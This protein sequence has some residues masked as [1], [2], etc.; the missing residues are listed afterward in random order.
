MTPMPNPALWKTY[1]YIP[2]RVTELLPSRHG[3]Q[4]KAVAISHLPAFVLARI[5]T[6]G[7]EGNHEHP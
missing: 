7:E 4:V 3:A 5:I 2:D 6:R 1:K